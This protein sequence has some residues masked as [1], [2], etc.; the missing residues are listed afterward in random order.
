MNVKYLPPLTEDEYVR[1]MVATFRNTIAEL[2]VAG[3]RE[4]RE[5]KHHWTYDV[6]ATKLR[7]RLEKLLVWLCTSLDDW[8]KFHNCV[9]QDWAKYDKRVDFHHRYMNLLSHLVR[10]FWPVDREGHNLKDAMI[11]YL[12]LTETSSA[13]TVH[14]VESSLAIKLKDALNHDEK[15][16]RYL[17]DWLP[18]H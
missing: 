4:I 1:L 8:A 3:R 14:A 15:K 6:P 9:V 17:H 10:E 18:T 7:S 2:H 12:G 16:L 11:A 5:P 13:A